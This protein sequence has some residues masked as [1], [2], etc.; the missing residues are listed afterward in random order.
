M[1]LCAPQWQERDQEISIDSGSNL[2]STLNHASLQGLLE[3]KPWFRYSISLVLLWIDQM[4]G[5]SMNL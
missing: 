2:W 1:L 5:S 4:L 3:L